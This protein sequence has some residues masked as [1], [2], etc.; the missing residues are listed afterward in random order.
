M[1]DLRFRSFIA[2][3]LVVAAIGLT[4]PHFAHGQAMS[5]TAAGTVH[6][7]P[8]ICEETLAPLSLKD[9]LRQVC[10]RQPVAMADASARKTI[11]IGFVGGFVKR[12][13]QR[14]PEVQ[15]ATG[16]RTFSFTMPPNTTQTPLVLLQAG[17]ISGTISVSLQ[18]TASGINVTPPN[19]APIAIIVPKVAPTV[20]AVTFSTSGD[21]LTVVVTGYS[22]TREI[23]SATFSFT[24]A[25]GASL[26][27]KSITVPAST[28]FGTW[29]TTPESAQYGSSFTYTQ[30]FT[31]SGPATAVGGVGVTLTNTIGTS[32][33]VTSQ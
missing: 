3:L 29:Y 5:L 8:T 33:E 16:G 13:D 20:S 26:A 32:T 7:A 30:L 31:L 6:R 21:T 10:L 1:R 24:P 17:T 19:L 9:A 15:F 22:S 18:L 2:L 27:E 28:L 25:M 11:I 14:H 23:Q 4:V 12:D